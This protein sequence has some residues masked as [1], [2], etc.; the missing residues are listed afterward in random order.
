MRSSAAATARRADA[1]K[2]L[3]AAGCTVQTVKALPSNDHSVT[4]ARGDVHEVEHVA[5]DE[6]PALPGAGRLGR[7][8]R[9][10]AC[11]PR[12]ST[13][14][15]TA[16]SSSSTART[17]RRRRSTQLKGVLRQPPERNAPR[18]AA[19]PRLEDR[20]RRLDDEQRVLARQ[21]H[22]APREVHDVRREGVRRVLR[23]LPVQGARAVPEELAARPARRTRTRACIRL[24]ADS[25]CRGGETGHTR[26]T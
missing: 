21:R 6:R 23:G 19:E 17:F 14:S 24:D 15:S 18:A 2:L 20:D 8:H 4:D 9:A 10:A 13:T 5:A 12:W 22:G 3:E 25:T 16:A 26:P 7:V 1:P 11:R